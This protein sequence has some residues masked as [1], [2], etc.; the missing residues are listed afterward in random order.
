MPEHL[1]ASYT[2]PEMSKSVSMNHTDPEVETSISRP[3]GLVCATPEH[4][5][6]EVLPAQ[7]V[8]RELH[9]HVVQLR[10]LER[11][12]LT[13]GPGQPG[14]G[15]HEGGAYLKLRPNSAPLNVQTRAP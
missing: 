13:H 14:P 15:I 1:N 5:A 9:R 8:R 7:R 11:E 10:V 12:L 3:R 4:L 2:L 6:A